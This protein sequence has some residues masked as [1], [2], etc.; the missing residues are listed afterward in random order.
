MSGPLAAAGVDALGAL[1]VD[2]ALDLIGLDPPDA[3]VV[4]VAPGH[5]RST[6]GRLCRSSAAPVVAVTADLGS[7]DEALGAGAAD[8]VVQPVDW[9]DLVAR[10]VTVATG[11]PPATMEPPV[12]SFTD[13]YLLVDLETGEAEVDGEPVA[14]SHN[15]R[16][17]LAALLY[18]AGAIVS[19]ERLEEALGPGSRRREAAFVVARLRHKLAAGHLSPVEEVPTGGFRYRPHRSAP[20]PKARLHAS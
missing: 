1:G 2:Q 16:R 20:A 8:A 12:P 11:P 5:S 14:L 18:E 3:V 9:P 15:E 19:I 7:L 17:V 4:E 6:L 10:L 13:G